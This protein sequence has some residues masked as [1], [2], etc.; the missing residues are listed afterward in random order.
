MKSFEFQI[1]RHRWIPMVT[2]LISVVLGIW[3]LCSPVTSVPV[4]AYLFAAVLCVAGL[5]NLVFAAINSRVMASWGW[6]LA[7]GLLD[8]VAGVWMFCMPEAELALMFVIVLGIWLVCVSIN[9]VCEAF[10]M[11][12]GSSFWWTFLSIVL[13]CVTIYFAI[14][15]ISS[16]SAMAVAGWLYLG[17]SLIA[18][19]T[20]RMS[21]SW[22]LGQLNR[23][24]RRMR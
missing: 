5:F 20:F 9:A 2:G 21:V 12:S 14:L 15:V 11:S 16:P 18:Y 17:I 22:Q 7:L 8:I 3:C 4:M 1:T 10:M 23:K 24:V 6:A 13:L 19:G